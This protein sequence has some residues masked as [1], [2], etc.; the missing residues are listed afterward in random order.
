MEWMPWRRQGKGWS[1]DWNWQ[2]GGRHNGSHAS[3]GHE[4]HVEMKELVV[5]TSTNNLVILVTKQDDE[6]AKDWDM[7]KAH[8]VFYNTKQKA[9]N[10]NMQVATTRH[11]N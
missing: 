10:N 7:L 1:T 11:D 5:L 9:W 6:K 3:R 8:V 4:G 2:K